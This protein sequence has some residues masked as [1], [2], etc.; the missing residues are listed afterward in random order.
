VSEYTYI[1]VAHEAFK[2]TFYETITIEDGEDV[3]TAVEAKLQELVDNS[4]LDDGDSYEIYS[5]MVLKIIDAHQV[6]YIDVH[7]KLESM[8]G[9]YERDS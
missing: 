9:D 4:D 7:V 3:E 1:I 5:D 6:Q 8:E 2:E